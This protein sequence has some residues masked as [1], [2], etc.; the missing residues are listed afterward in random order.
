ME[1]IQE[2][3]KKK[4]LEEAVPNR[5]PRYEAFLEKNGTGWLV[6]KKVR[7]YVIFNFM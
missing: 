1:T 3:L 4:V 7:I 5:F 6:G 2:E